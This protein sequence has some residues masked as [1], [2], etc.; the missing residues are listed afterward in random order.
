MKLHHNDA[1]V[2]ATTMQQNWW[3]LSIGFNEIQDSLDY[4]A[5]VPQ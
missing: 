5:S 2:L 1:S 3:I 4:D